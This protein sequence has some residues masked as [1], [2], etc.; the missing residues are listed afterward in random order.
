MK[1]LVFPQIPTKRHRFLILLLLPLIGACLEP[2]ASDFE[3]ETE[4]LKKDELQW[5]IR[6]PRSIH[7]DGVEWVSAADSIAAMTYSEP[8]FEQVLPLLIADIRAGR[9]KVFGF[10]D[11][12]RREE[13]PLA[14]LT[15][16]LARLNLDWRDISP[17]LHVFH[18]EERGLSRNGTFSA[19]PINLEILWADPDGKIPNHHIAR[20]RVADLNYPIAVAGREMDFAD[21]LKARQYYFFPIWVSTRERSLGIST[22]DQAYFLREKVL[23]G[24]WDSV[25]FLGYFMNMA[26][27]TPVAAE[28]AQLEAAAGLYAFDAA[29]FPE[30]QGGAADSIQLYVSIKQ[31]L[32][33]AEWSWK[34]GAKEE[35]YAENDQVFFTVMGDFFEFGREGDQLRVLVK[36]YGKKGGNVRMGRRVP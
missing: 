27:K 25:G 4:V 7:M 19:T 22:M 16:K 24:H 10:E 36:M 5:R 6:I 28:P 14:D 8:V 18:V 9:L 12:H 3:N 17:L 2:V 32:L 11:G 15:D 30:V 26:E 35:L 33:E 13:I 21:Y 31:D 34:N 29:D 20:V 23:R 1:N